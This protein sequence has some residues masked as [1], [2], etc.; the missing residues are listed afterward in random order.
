MQKNVNHIATGEMDLDSQ[1]SIG[2]RGQFE[3][4]FNS[5]YPGYESFV[6]ISLYAFDEEKLTVKILDLVNN[7]FIYK[8]KFK[9]DFLAKLY[10]RKK[11]NLLFVIV[12]PNKN[13]RMRLTVNLHCIKCDENFMGES[14][15]LKGKSNLN[16]Y[17]INNKKMI[18]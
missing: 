18:W 9:A 7:K 8:K 6:Y 11:E 4:K 1:I 3:Y 17:L 15:A 13:K 10:F 16:I 14:R 5:P 2:P 12:N